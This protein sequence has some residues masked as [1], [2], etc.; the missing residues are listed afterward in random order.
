MPNVGMGSTAFKRG[1]HMRLLVVL[2]CL[3]G[4]CAS[5]PPSTSPG[6]LIIAHRG[7][8]GERPEHTLAAYE[9]AIDQ[10]ADFIEPD[11]VITKDGVLIARHENEIRGTTDISDHPEFADRRTEKLIDGVRVTGFFTEDFTLAELKTLRARE[12]LPEL[13]GTAHDG[14]FE[15][16]TFDEIIALAKNR[17]VGIYS[18]TK[19]PTYFQNLGK[20][21][22]PPLLY[23][24]RLFG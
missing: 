15:I 16:P 1:I 4:G 5:T 19:H 8:S 20:P 24:L 11:L 2:L 3:L 7:A 21:L 17:G 22:E 18:E 14:L 10:G 23:T 13:R 9:L 12:R 6:V